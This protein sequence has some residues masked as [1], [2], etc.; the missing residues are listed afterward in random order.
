MKPIQQGRR[1]EVASVCN[2]RCLPNF[3]AGR[4]TRRDERVL[5]LTMKPTTLRTDRP[6]SRCMTPAND[7]ADG[8]PSRVP[9]AGRRSWTIWRDRPPSRGKV[10]MMPTHAPYFAAT[11][12]RCCGRSSTQFVAGHRIRVRVD[13]SGFVHAGVAGSDGAWIRVYKV[14]LLPRP[15]GGSGAVLPAGVNAFTFFWTEARWTPGHPGQ[16]ERE[17]QRSVHGTRAAAC[18]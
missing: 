7:F 4:R 17:P 15:G 6:V 3:F 16:W 9:G 18:S 12:T 8:K 11:L 1:R 10:D 2:E 5:V 13:G 14:P